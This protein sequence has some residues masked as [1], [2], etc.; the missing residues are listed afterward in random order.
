MSSLMPPNVS[1]IIG[2]GYGILQIFLNVR[3][4]N[5][6]NYLKEDVI[7]TGMLIVI[8]LKRQIIA[9]LIKVVK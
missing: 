1:G 4:L 3:N 2:E 6:G 7:H 9:K 8:S 5:G